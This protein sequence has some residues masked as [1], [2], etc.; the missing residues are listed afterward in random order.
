[1]VLLRPVEDFCSFYEKDVLFSLQIRLEHYNTLFLIR[2]DGSDVDLLV[3]LTGAI[4]VCLNNFPE[5]TIESKGI[6]CKSW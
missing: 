3:H 2:K 5:D 6:D 4:Q 1:M